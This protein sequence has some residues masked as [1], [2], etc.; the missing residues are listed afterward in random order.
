MKNNELYRD[1]DFVVYM[2]GKYFNADFLTELKGE[3]S[4]KTNFYFSN[5]EEFES[6]KDRFNKVRDILKTLTN[7]FEFIM[8][9]NIQYVECCSCKIDVRYKLTNDEIAERL[10]TGHT[11]KKEKA[12]T[13]VKELVARRDDLNSS[14]ETEITKLI[15]DYQ[16]TEYQEYSGYINFHKRSEA[17]KNSMTD[18]LQLLK[19]LNSERETA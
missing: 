19:E 18:V 5:L 3:V 14:E 11:E 2:Q 4:F 16:L 6:F 12:I 17:L 7:D 10:F 1:N 15:A 8:A 13:R 9:K